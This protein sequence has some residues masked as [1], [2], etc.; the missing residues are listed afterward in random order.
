[1]ADITGTV[2]RAY[3]FTAPKGNQEVHTMTAKEREIVGCFVDVEYTTGTYATA[4]TALFAPATAIQ[5]ALRDGQT[6]TILQ[7]CFADSGK[8]A[9]SG[10]DSLIGALGCTVSGGTVS[11]DLSLEDLATE[12]TNATDTATFTWKRPITYFVTFVRPLAGE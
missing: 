6:V 2:K 11:N 9:I 4:N 3:G 5:D 7:A 12:Y 8:I 10:T 1:M